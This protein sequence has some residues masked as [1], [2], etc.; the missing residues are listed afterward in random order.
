MAITTPFEHL[1][2]AMHIGDDELPWV[3]GRQE[4]T[5]TKV[6]LAKVKE[7]LW[8]VR[9]RFG[10]GVEI[11]THRHTGPVYAFT[12]AGS[13]GY[14]ESE[15]MNTAG[16]FLYEPAGSLHTLFTPES[17]DEETDVWFAIYGANLNLDDDGNVESVTDAASVLASYLK[18]ARRQGIDNPPVLTDETS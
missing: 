14:R 10:A 4:D 9:T 6:V 17:N 11:Q 3:T 2:S 5:Q 8:I 13:W 7:G 15:Y 16:S 12:L 18:G 1:P